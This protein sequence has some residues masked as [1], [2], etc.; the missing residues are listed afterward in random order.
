MRGGGGE[1]GSSE[2]EREREGEEPLDR[3]ELGVGARAVVD[4]V[5]GERRERQRVGQRQARWAQA[6]G[7]I[8]CTGIWTW[9]HFS[10]QIIT[11]GSIESVFSL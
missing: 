8:H 5:L 6:Q 4:E 11:A 1:R 3:R 2:R 9:V 7:S 10:H